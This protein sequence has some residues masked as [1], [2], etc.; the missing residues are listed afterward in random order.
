MDNRPHGRQKTVGTGSVGAHKGS[1]TG[2]RPVGGGRTG[3]TS[4]G[5]SGPQRGLPIQLNM[6]TILILVAAVLVIILLFKFCGG[7]SIDPGS[8]I[9]PVYPTAAPDSGKVD[10]CSYTAVDYTVSRLARDKRVTPVG[11]G[12][13]IVNV[14]VYMCG[15]D[16]ES[17]YGM[18]TKDLKEMM[19]AQIADNVNLIVL[20]GGCKNW[21]NDVISSS[22]NQIYQV[23]RGGLVCLKDNFGTKSMTDPTN[24]TDFLDYCLTNY[25]NA[26]RNMLIF[27]DHGGGSLSGY[28]YDEKTNS[29][30]MT[31]AKIDSALSNAKK[32]YEAKNKGKTFG[33]D[34]IGFDACL[35]AT[36]ETALVMNNYAD[37]LLASEET[38]PGT[39]W[40][41][42][43]W[44]NQLSRNT[45]APTLD[46]AKTVIDTFVSTAAGDK[47]TLSVIDLAEL[48]GTVP[49]AF[50]Q[51]ASSTTELLTTDDYQKISEARA[52]VR[53]FS[54]KIN[55][56]DL[57]DLANRIG[58]DDAKTL[59]SAL[60]G[61]V[62]YNRS[63][64][65]RCYG[66]S[67][68]FPYETTKNVKTAL[69]SYEDIGIADEYAECIKSF[70]SLEVGGQIAGSAS[71]LPSGTSIGSG[72]LDS[73]ISSYTSSGSST[74][75]V[76]ALLGSF[77][78]GSTPSAGLGLD[79]SSVLSLLSGFS[80]RSMPGEYDWVD[81]GLIAQNAQQIASDTLDPSHI[82]ASEKNGKSVLQRTEEEWSLVQNAELNVY[83]K[84]GEGYI[85]LGFDNTLD[86]NNDGDLLLT[87]DGTWLTLDGHLVAYYMLSDTEQDD[88]SWITLGRIP[89]LLNDTEMNLLV[90][91]N[92]GTGSAKIMGAY[93]LYADVDV[94]AKGAIEVKAG[95]TI[96]PLCDYYNLDGTY[97]ASYKL[98]EAFT[99]SKLKLENLRV[100]AQEFSA[101]YRLTD[102]FGNHY[103]IEAK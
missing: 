100:D 64:I 62:K 7:P 60:R 21:Q 54:E 55:Q 27:W 47:T 51:F 95:D 91:F 56:V 34:F 85:N 23:K 37:Y 86:Y 11:D 79:A 94:A 22:K 80:G 97:E 17:K 96:Q 84:D 42:T 43:D 41:Y 76:S 46:L 61:S 9:D 49:E 99:A 1:Q 35:M 6:K 19:N 53:Q 5:P 57:V 71:Q 67:I 78:T 30:S 77:T 32:N 63:S 92:D 90:E 82:F 102:V 31:L 74:S 66:V 25:D 28:G 87:F 93:P 16:L 101:M 24:L 4:G 83:V 70:A 69:A 12:E 2:S 20:T 44:L 89:V 3:G 10:P 38:E 29:S 103:W 8:F 40:Y 48:S 15:T 18:A 98:N 39:G 52:G 65:S 13:D 26:T 50:R 72:L 14:M 88:G 75:P 36:L 58:T 81:T 59:A 33:L 45:S 68:F 73:L